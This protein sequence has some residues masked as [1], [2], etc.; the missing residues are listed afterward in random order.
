MSHLCYVGNYFGAFTRAV[1]YVIEATV[2]SRSQ[3][4]PPTAEDLE[5]HRRLVHLWYPSL[6]LV[7]KRHAQLM[8]AI[9][10]LNGQW[11]LANY[12]HQC[13]LN[14]EGR[15]CCSSGA[16]VLEQMRRYVLILLLSSRP[17]IVT[18]TRW[19]SASTCVGWRAI[20]LVLH[21][22]YIRAFVRAWPTVCRHAQFS[23]A[24]LDAEQSGDDDDKDLPA[25]TL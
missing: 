10:F 13:V 18:K 9:G 8:G 7:K 14:A 24:D 12:F 21:K 11:S 22:S 16:E 23:Q 2:I 6:H 25:W 1:L 3:I 4:V 5:H 19:L 17:E 20:G 15:P